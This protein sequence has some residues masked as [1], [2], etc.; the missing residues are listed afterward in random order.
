[1]GCGA[2]A[3]TKYKEVETDDVGPC[4]STSTTRSTNSTVST[5]AP[6]CTSVC[7]DTSSVDGSETAGLFV[8][9]ARTEEAVFNLPVGAASFDKADSERNSMDGRADA[10]QMCY[11]VTLDDVS[12][13]RL[14]VVKGLVVAAKATISTNLITAAALA[15]T[16][17]AVAEAIPMLSGSDE[18]QMVGR[19]V[20]SRL[21][22]TA[23]VAAGCHS[24]SAPGLV[25][26]A[27]SA[28]EATAR[29]RS[30]RGYRRGSDGLVQPSA[31][32]CT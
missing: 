14:A 30:K 9:F 24:A 29:A 3:A 31:T 21:A 1:M 5:Y 2:S 10:S 8:A 17:A 11:A 20:A 32:F 7:S 22:A 18:S 13:D 15:T 27:L 6:S 26:T 28:A 23:T 4:K 12:S 19:L 16:A 25:K